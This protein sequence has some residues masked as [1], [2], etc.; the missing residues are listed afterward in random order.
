MSCKSNLRSFPD[1]ARGC[2]CPFMLCLHPHYLRI[3]VWASRSYQEQIGKSRSFGMWHHHRGYVSNF[4]VRQPHLRCVEKVGNP[5][6]T[7]Q[8]NRP[9]IRD[10]EGHIKCKRSIYLAGDILHSVRV[11]RLLACSAKLLVVNLMG[12]RKNLKSKPS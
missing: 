3:G 9:S 5:L 12:Q 1:D 2:Q 8:G 7:K 11:I 6:Q 4:L 10:Q